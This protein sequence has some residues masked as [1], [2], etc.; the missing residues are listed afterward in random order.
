MINRIL[1]MGVLA[2][3]TVAEAI[4]DRILYGLLLFGIGLILL[5]AVLSNLTVGFRLRIVTDISLS[6]IM[7]AGTIMAVLLGVGSIAK[8]IEKKTAYPLLAKPISRGEYIIGKYL[9]VLSTTYINVLL[10]MA[11]ATFMIAQYREES[12]HHAYAWNAFII[13]LLF[14]LIRL[15]VVASVAVFF[16]TFGSSTFALISSVGFTVA[17]YFT[18][19]LRFFL[20][21]SESELLRAIGKGLYY[22]MPDFAMLDPLPLLIHNHPIFTPSTLFAAVYALAYALCL[23]TLSAFLFSRR[24]LG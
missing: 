7:A 1:A 21:K 17:G 3:T 13:T 15:A 19:E 16:S 20:E 8:E 14:L 22:T 12:G 11:A 10:M 18:S 2:R 9:G 23:L 5:S 24:D 4:R 6:A